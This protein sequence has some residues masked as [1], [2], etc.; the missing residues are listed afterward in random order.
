MLVRSS[1][2]CWPAGSYH[3][4]FGSWKIENSADRSA[5]ETGSSC[6]LRLAT[7]C[8]ST[9]RTVLV[10]TGLDPAVDRPVVQIPVLRIVRRQAT[11]CPVDTTQASLH[12]YYELGKERERLTAGA[13]RLELMRTI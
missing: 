3:Q 13:G 5:I 1:S 4:P 7:R 10:V 6:S 12:A 9:V 8:S 11:V 2:R